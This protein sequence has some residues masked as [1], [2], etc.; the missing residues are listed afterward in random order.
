MGDF[1]EGFSHT[2]SQMMN[3]LCSP[4][5]NHRSLSGNRLETV[6]ATYCINFLHFSKSKLPWGTVFVLSAVICNDLHWPPVVDAG[7]M[8]HNTYSVY[9]IFIV[10]NWRDYHHYYMKSPLIIYIFLSCCGISCNYNVNMQG[11]DF[12]VGSM[13]SFSL[14][15]EVL[16]DI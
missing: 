9:S 11:Q 16:S 2:N 8:F 13:I 3:Y 15:N 4:S 7:K 14:E 10:R 1:K 12:I 6:W 5:C